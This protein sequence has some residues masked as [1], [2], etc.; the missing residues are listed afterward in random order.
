MILQCCLHINVIV[1]LNSKTQALCLISSR[2]G[3]NCFISEL[4]SVVFNLGV[5][6]LNVGTFG[7]SK[8]SFRQLEAVLESVKYS[9]A[10]ARVSVV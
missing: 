5:R 6:F 10:Q 9:N 8:S 2:F 7:S 4:S 3:K 1:L